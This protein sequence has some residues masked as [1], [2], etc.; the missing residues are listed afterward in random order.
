VVTGLV[1]ATLI[2][3]VVGPVRAIADYGQA[4]FIAFVGVLFWPVPVVAAA[5]FIGPHFNNGLLGGLIP[6]TARFRRTAYAIV[7]TGVLG[8]AFAG[9]FGV[10]WMLNP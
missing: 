4:G 6:S 7:V 3:G 5:I 9:L 2:L 10:G 8:A 1:G